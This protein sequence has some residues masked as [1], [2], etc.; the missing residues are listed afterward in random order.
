M[1]Q[2]QQILCKQ[3][4]NVMQ[5]LLKQFIWVK[6]QIYS[7]L[8]DFS[9]IIIYAPFPP[10]TNLQICR[11]HQKMVY[12][13]SVVPYTTLYI[14]NLKSSWQIQHNKWFSFLLLVYWYEH[15]ILQ[16]TMHLRL[17]GTTYCTVMQNTVQLTINITLQRN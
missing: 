9:F 2:N 17:C 3:H 12:S 15:S 14:K 13:K 8:H 7:V 5:H 11:V 1:M 6:Y 10:N 4:S 16:C